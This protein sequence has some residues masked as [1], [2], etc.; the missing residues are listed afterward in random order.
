MSDGA[1]PIGYA[2]WL[3]IKR[4]YITKKRVGQPVN[5]P[6]PRRL[7]ATIDK[8]MLVYEEEF[9][10]FEANEES[11]SGWWCDAMNRDLKA[12]GGW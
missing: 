7:L 5:V 8:L 6:M 11:E 9:G 2:E 10:P 4:E 12:V 3:Q 1:A